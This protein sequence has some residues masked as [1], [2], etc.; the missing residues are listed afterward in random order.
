[1]F[2]L[3]EFFVKNK[4][5]AQLVYGILLI[6]LVIFFISFNSFSI[7]KKYKTGLNESLNHQAYFYAKSIYTLMKPNLDDTATLQKQIDSLLDKNSEIINFSILKENDD[8]FETI[9]STDVNSIGKKN[10]FYL[11]KFAWQQ[12]DYQGVATD[13]FSA[14]MANNDEDRNFIENLKTEGT[15]WFVALPMYDESGVKKAILSVVIS[16]RFE[17][18]ITSK[19]KTNSLVVT[20]ISIVAVIMFLSLVLR[21][22]DYAFLYK[23]V[24]EVDE[25]KDEFISMASHEL[26][27]PVTGIKG[28]SSMIMDGSFGVVNEQIKNGATII[29]AAANR[30]S[31]L[32][33]DLLNVSRIEQGRMQIVLKPINIHQIINEVVQEL[34]V[35]ADQKKLKLIYESAQI[36]LPLVAIDSDR[37]KQVL[38]N[39]IGNSIKYTETGKVEVSTERLDNKLAVKIKDTGLGM[40]AEARAKLFQ[41]FYRVQTVKTKNITGTGLGLWITKQI[42]ELM[43]GSIEVESMEGTGSQFTIKFPIVAKMN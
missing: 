16:S 17:D 41:K 43:K 5:V 34:K 21:I 19:N 27:T 4:E 39:L 32:V 38:I 3:K 20:L 24:K 26:R 36:D 29:N 8:G 1:M 23:K 14:S 2:N 7:I 9:A 31:I 35:Q 33:D 12:P 13:S 40:S 30:L 37:L 6:I 10:S 42:V 15:N 25:M 11:Y 22:W 18:G 28:Y